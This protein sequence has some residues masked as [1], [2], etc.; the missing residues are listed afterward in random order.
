VYRQIIPLADIVFAG[1]DEAE[2]A[3]GTSPSAEE[4]GRR[5][6]QLGPREVVIKL[7]AHGA[8]ALIDGDVY[9]Q[10]AVPVAVVDTVGA[11]DAFVAGYLAEFVNQALPATRLE[12]AAATGAFAC[13]V[14]GDW[15][16]FPRREELSLL[17]ASE[18][19]L[20]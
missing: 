4:L 18:P 6:A 5:L 13:L 8:L 2:I 9:R 10:T 19:V 17:L 16:G 1:S 14:P 3:V 20:R 12:T 15:E 7:G 11:G